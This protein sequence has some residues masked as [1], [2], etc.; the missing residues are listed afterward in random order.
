M[1]FAISPPRASISR[2]RCPLAS[3]P[4][5]GLHDMR[6]MASTLI[7]RSRV[8]HPVRAAARDASIPAWPPPTTTTSYSFGYS[9]TESAVFAHMFHVEQEPPLFPDAEGAEDRVEDLFG[10]DLAGELRQ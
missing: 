1:S 10:G 4:I 5:A 3:P 2:T 6:P 9:Y 8:A 7:V